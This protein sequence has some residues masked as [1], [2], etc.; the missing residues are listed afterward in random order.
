L[1]HVEFGA[2]WDACIA[3]LGR[4]AAQEHIKALLARG[5]RKPGD[6]EDRLGHHIGQL[7]G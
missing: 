6:T 2:G 5:F 1:R 3:S 7:A 4:P